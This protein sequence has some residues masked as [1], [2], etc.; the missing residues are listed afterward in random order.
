MVKVKRKISRAPTCAVKFKSGAKCLERVGAIGDLCPKHA[1]TPSTVIVG[2]FS[3]IKRQSIRQRLAS[4]QKFERDAMDL[5]PEIELMRAIMINWIEDFDEFAEA[6]MAWNSTLERGQRPVA[7]PKI[8]DVR[9]LVETIGKLVAKQ[10]EIKNRSSISVEDFHRV[11]QQMGAAVAAFVT[12]SN[13]LKQIELAWGNLSL[14]SKHPLTAR[15]RKLAAA[16]VIDVTPKD[17]DGLDH[18]A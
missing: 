11:L 17:D 8:E 1:K 14:D 3:D 2:R 6:I 7:I 18:T 12:D 16:E 9:G 5:L 15:Q 10:N 13:A 4:I